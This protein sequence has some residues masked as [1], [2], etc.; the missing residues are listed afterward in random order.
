MYSTLSLAALLLLG[1]SQVDA[2][3]ADKVCTT[4]SASTIKWQI[5]DFDFHGTYE[6]TTP[7]HQNSWGVAKFTLENTGLSYKAECSGQ[8]SQLPDFFYGNVVY[9]CTVPAEDGEYGDKSSF[10]FS[11][12]DGGLLI[13][14][15][16]GCEPDGSKYHGEGAVKLD[17]KCDEKE[18]K[19]PKW[20]MGQIYSRKDVTCAKVSAPVNITYLSAFA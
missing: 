7:A 13:N 5:K 1:G 18:W 15:T 11:K 8:A 14:Q 12:S 20:E 17:L 3:A 2:R 6:F 4:K 10:T 19:N 9:N 16:W